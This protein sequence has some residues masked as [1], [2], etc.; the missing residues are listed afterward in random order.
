[1]NAYIDATRTDPAKLPADYVAAAP[2]QPLPQ[3]WTDADVVSIAGLI[4]GIFG[5]GGGFEV[6]DA[7]L[8]HLPAAAATAPPPG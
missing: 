4:G 2:D 1:M 8:L 3:K 6:N 5:K 7:H